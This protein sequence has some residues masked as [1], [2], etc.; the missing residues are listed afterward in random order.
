MPAFEGTAL[1]YNQ[2]TMATIK[3]QN[4]PVYDIDHIYV[5]DTGDD[6]AERKMLAEAIVETVTITED[7]RVSFKFKV[8]GEQSAFSPDEMVIYYDIAAYRATDKKTECAYKMIS[9][10]LNELGVSSELYNTFKANPNAYQYLVPS[11]YIITDDT[12]VAAIDFPSTWEF[13]RTE[14]TVEPEEPDDVSTIQTIWKHNAN[15]FNRQV[16]PTRE[17]AL[18]D[19]KIKI[20]RLD[21]TEDEV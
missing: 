18:K 8:A 16:F 1:L 6:N 17:E 2:N 11:G 21:G 5:V 20:C 13:T 4:I 9:E 3:N 10:L 15:F 7:G 12:M 19:H 14:I